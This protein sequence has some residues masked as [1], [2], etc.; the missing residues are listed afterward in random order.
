MAQQADLIST[1]HE[2]R[3]YASFFVGLMVAEAPDIGVRW[4]VLALPATPGK[5]LVEDV[6]DD[7]GI[8][9]EAARCV[10]GC[11]GFAVLGG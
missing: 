3:L 2:V 8:E 7:E 11:C 10:A 9:T 1:G 4:P 6:T 5:G